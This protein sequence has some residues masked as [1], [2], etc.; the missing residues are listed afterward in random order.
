MEILKLQNELL[1]CLWDLELIGIM[2]R[3]TVHE[4]F[5]RNVSFENGRYHVKL[6]LKEKHDTLPDNYELSLARLDSQ[7]KRL[8][9]N[10]PLLKDYD[11]IFKE[12]LD[13]GI[14]ERVED[15]VQEHTPGITHYIPHQAGVKK[16]ATTT[17]V[18]VVYD[19]SAKDKP[20]CLSLN[21]CVYTV[22]S[23]ST[24]ILK[25]LLC[26][27][28]RK[29][30]LVADIEKAFLNIAID[31]EQRDMI[32]FLWV[33]NIGNDNPYVEVYQFCRVIF[34]MKC[35]PFL[36]NSTLQHHVT[37]YYCDDPVFAERVLSELYVDDWTGGDETDDGAYTLYQKMKSSF[38][39]M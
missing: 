22:P 39:C 4:A 5:E 38:F 15:P 13:Q 35:S 14:I 24:E 29:I 10:P 21:D 30:R 25:I 3:E 1:H 33:E 8:R 26:F 2:D 34:G 18:R 6:P 7:V 32:Q 28:G 27:R 16:E 9:Q 17:K 37:N 31:K 20:R 11:Q 36:L 19:A 23:L 12:H